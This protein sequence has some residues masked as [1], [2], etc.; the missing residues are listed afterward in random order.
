MAKLMGSITLVTRVL[1]F[2]NV[3]YINAKGKQFYFSQA[4]ESYEDCF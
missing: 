2:D 4:L 1:T 3:F